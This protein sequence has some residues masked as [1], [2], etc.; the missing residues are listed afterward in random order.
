MRDQ[1][2]IAKEMF[3][4]REDLEQNLGA[5]K[6]AVRDKIDLPNRVRHAIA[7]RKPWLVGGAAAVIAL[8][9]SALVL[10]RHR[11]RNRPWWER[12]YAAISP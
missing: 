5:L 3:H 1:E 12:A 4:A 8:G 9:V 10:L 11:A 2:E 7:D 6:D